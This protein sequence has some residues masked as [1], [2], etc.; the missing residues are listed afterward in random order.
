M[1]RVAVLGAT[2]TMGALLCPELERRG[3]DVVRI[4]RA[5]GVDVADPAALRVALE[6]ADAVVDCL[7]LQTMSTR[8]ATGFFTSAAQAVTTAAPSLKH[9]VVV[10]IL[11]VDDPAV[12]RIVGYYRANTNRR[13]RIA[14]PLRSGS[15]W[16]VPLNGSRSGTWCAASFAWDRS[17]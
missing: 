1:S 16:Y 8:R 3:H 6:N 17:R 14:K 11:N 7:N 10:S 9:V 5:D 2:G 4:S 12:Q 15:R 13:R